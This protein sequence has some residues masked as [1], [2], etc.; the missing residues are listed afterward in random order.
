MATRNTSALTV[1]RLRE[2]LD[3]DPE[4]GVFRW[5]ERPE[6]CSRDKSWNTKWCGQVAGTLSKANG[7][8]IISIGK[9]N[10]YS[11]RLAWLFVHGEWPRLLDH[12]NRIKSDNRLKNLREATVSQNA[13]NTP[14][15]S[16]N[17]SGYRGVSFFKKNSTWAAQVNSFGKHIHL[18]YFKTPQEAA[19]VALSW[20]K[21]NFPYDPS[22][23]G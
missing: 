4:T 19:R 16:N 10:F 12:R 18:G 17:T 5:K 13:Q 20:R 11:H 3:Y 23:E 7:Y 15:K 1:E 2:L 14:L 22:N 9:R 8:I 21:E 6:H